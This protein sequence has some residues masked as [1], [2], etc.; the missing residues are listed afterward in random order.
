MTPRAHLLILVL[1]AMTAAAALAAGDGIVVYRCA[2]C[3]APIE[4]YGWAVSGKHY[5]ADCLI[6]ANPNPDECPI[7]FRCPSCGIP[8]PVPGYCEPCWRRENENDDCG[9]LLRLCPRCHHTFRDFSPQR[10]RRPALCPA[11]SVPP[12]PPAA[13]APYPQ[14]PPSPPSP[15]PPRPFR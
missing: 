4:A 6:R 11:C 15:R 5:C 9:Y 12:P 1:F 14:M 10:T 7:P 2:T 3:K 13:P 8:L